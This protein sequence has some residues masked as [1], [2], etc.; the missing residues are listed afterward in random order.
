MKI[1]CISGKAGHGKDYTADLLKNNLEHL[2][3]TVLIIHYADLLKFICSKYLGWDGKKDESGRTL[4]Q[5]IGTEVVRGYNKDFWVDFVFKVLI[6]FEPE[7]DF[8][9]IPDCRFE[10]EILAGSSYC[11]ESVD[12]VKVKRIG[13]DSQLTEEQRNHSSETELDDI[14]PDYLLINDGTE[15]YKNAVMQLTHSI[16]NG[17]ATFGG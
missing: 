3:Y 15:E 7:W 10:N 13:Y 16:V 14:D 4:L 17:V 1:V 6:M 5:H 8:A 12:H 2:G 9:I 11:F